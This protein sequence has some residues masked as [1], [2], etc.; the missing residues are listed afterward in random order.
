MKREQ[1]ITAIGVFVVG[2]GLGYG[3]TWILVSDDDQGKDAPS[4]PVAAGA[5]IQENVASQGDTSPAPSPEADTHSASSTDT[6]PG[7]PAEAPDTKTVEEAPP[8]EEAPWW[9]ACLGKP[10]KVDF[11]GV[12][13]GLSIRRGSIKHGSIVDWNLRFKNARRLEILPTDRSATVLLRAVGLSGSGQPVAAE[14]E[15]KTARQ[16]IVGVIS[17]QPGDK[18]VTM[19]PAQP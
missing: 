8:Q 6:G 7:E 5:D 1:I 2:F 3:A 13:G 9:K 4:A 12:R 14:I 16:T 19:Q 10:S 11:G 17:L 15:W 18:R